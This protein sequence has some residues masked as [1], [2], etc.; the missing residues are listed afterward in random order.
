MGPSQPGVRGDQLFSSGNARGR[1]TPGMV[2]HTDSQAPVHPHHRGGTCTS[3]LQPPQKEGRR[4]T[5]RMELTFNFTISE[6]S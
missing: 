6:K 4:G 5:S 3:P 2:A 1:H